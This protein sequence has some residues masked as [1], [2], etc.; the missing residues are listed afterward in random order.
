MFEKIISQKNFQLIFICHFFKVKIYKKKINF[1]KKIRL[2]KKV[3]MSLVEV[4]GRLQIINFMP[5][6]EFHLVQL[7]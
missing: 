6:H 1:C 4:V 3:E 2:Y 7:S 5:W